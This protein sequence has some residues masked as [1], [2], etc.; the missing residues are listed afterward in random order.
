[1]SNV[2]SAVGEAAARLGGDDA[3]FDAELL[4][5]HALGRTRAWLFAWP[6]FEL[7]AGQRATFEAFVDA[8]VAGRP[9][10]YLTGHREFWSLDLRVDA[11]V[12]IPRT[13]T[14]LL[15]ELALARMPV[16]AVCAVAD[17]GTGSGAIALALARDRPLAHVFA[18]DVSA[19]ALQVARDNAQRL[20]IGNVEFGHGDWCAALGE[21]RFDLIVSNPPYIASGDAHLLAGDLRHEPI[22][23]LASGSAGFDAIDAILAEVAAHLLPAAGLLLEHGFEQ[24]AAVR[25]RF[26]AHGFSQ[27]HTV[28][29]A[30]DR[31]RVTSGVRPF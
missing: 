20:D 16:D 5:A 31:E 17:L 6:E 12:L 1:V 2:R 25:E 3:R 26:A 8:R 24:G 19:A 22:A 23:A 18:T 29:D 4:L 7:D 13:E 30:E 15:V 11:A 14:E 27:V 21:R 28:R 9:I 10:A